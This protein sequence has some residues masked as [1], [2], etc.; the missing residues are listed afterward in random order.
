MVNRRNL[1]SYFER[2]NRPRTRIG[3]EYQVDIPPLLYCPTEHKQERDYLV[4]SPQD[5]FASTAMDVASSEEIQTDQPEMV[6]F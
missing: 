5:E 6:Y 3:A 2:E 1:D 4:N